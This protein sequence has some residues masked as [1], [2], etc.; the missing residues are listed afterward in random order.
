MATTD[1]AGAAENSIACVFVP[2]FP[3]QLLRRTLPDDFESPFAVTDREDAGAVIMFVDERAAE[4]KVHPG[5]R[6]STA[7]A[8]CPALHAASV[9]PKLIQN[10]H[11]AIMRQL[12]AFSPGIEP[13]RELP[14]AYYLDI[15]GMRRLAP[16]MRHW[17]ADVRDKLCERQRLRVNVAAG[18]TRFGVLTAACAMT[19]AGAV[20]VFDS[21]SDERY[22]AL[23]APLNLLVP[24]SAGL[25]ELIKLDVRT[26]KDLL[27]LP[28][29]ELRT[30]F[31][32]DLFNLAQQARSRRGAVY[33]AEL[34]QPYHA[35]AEFE[36]AQNDV[37]QLLDAVRHS[38]R[39]LLKRMQRN[40]HGA[41][42]LRLRLKLDC[43]AL[44]NEMLSTSEPTLDAAAI[45][46]LMRLRFSTVDFKQGVAGIS[47]RLIPGPLP[48]RQ[49]SLDQS[50]AKTAR[51]LAAAD[52]AL[53]LVCAEFGTQRVVR[54]KCVDSHLP[55]ESFCWEFFDRM[56]KPAPSQAQRPCLIRRI[57]DR[58]RRI[59]T[60]RRATL[61]RVVGPYLISG[62]WWRDTSVQQSYYYAESDTGGT[63]WIFYDSIARQWYEQ[64]S[65]Q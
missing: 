16:D 38:L 12:Q 29:H 37:E 27:R 35:H 39:P 28:A 6:Y 53:A 14:G 46:Q 20:A 23:K 44:R 57:H 56:R 51:K 61:K 58:P 11:D 52:Q 5:L 40:R 30:R 50:Y 43:G 63:Q 18:F 47:V 21:P 64:G 19:P 31:N 10:A 17:A 54:A 22:A 65:V 42:A 3:L 1:H 34:P 13:V 33:A 9:H 4:Q 7:A 60:P 15:R 26:V 36:Y 62:Y 49:F 45:I 48:D 32:Q 55:G 2:E 8:V 59:G 25:D 24:P 41:R